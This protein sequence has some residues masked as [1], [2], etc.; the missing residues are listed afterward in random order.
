MLLA[1]GSPRR[2]DILQA[3]GI[4]P[5]VCPVDA[6]ELQDGLPPCELVR[7]NALLKAQAAAELYPGRVILAADTLVALGDMPLGKPQDEADACRMLRL[8]SGRTHS[9]F[10]GVAVWADGELRADVAESRVTFRIL[11]D[12]EIAEYVAGGEPM[13]K[14]GAYAVQGVGAA[15]VSGIEGDFDNIVGLP[16]ALVRELLPSEIFP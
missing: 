16:M 11:T 5:E 14:A 2:L 15:L 8:L 13:D 4:K 12:G 10:T 7:Q 1:S 3:A 9:V 6:E